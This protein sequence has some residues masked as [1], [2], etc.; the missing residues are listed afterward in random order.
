MYKHLVSFNRFSLLSVREGDKAPSLYPNYIN[1]P[2]IFGLVYVYLASP[3][4]FCFHEQA[5][6]KEGSYVSLFLA[7]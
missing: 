3:P 2:R 1:H 7:N 6:S 5:F 4:G